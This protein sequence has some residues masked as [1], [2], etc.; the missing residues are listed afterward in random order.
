[1]VPKNLGIQVRQ[2]R[3]EE[4]LTIEQL[5]ERSGASV[6]FISRLERETVQSIKL[7]KLMDVLNALDMD[8]SS[9]FG[10]FPMDDLEEEL[11]GMLRTMPDNER[12]NKIR[13]ILTLM[14]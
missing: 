4:H 6:T 11:W 1:M 2:R 13:A 5:A 10:H 8:L 3:S 7:D 12:Q 14:K 9:I